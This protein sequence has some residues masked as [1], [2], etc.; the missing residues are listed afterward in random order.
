MITA[1]G[2]GERIEDL[3]QRTESS[4]VY[5]NPDGTWTSESSLSPERV[6]DELG[7]WHPID[8]TLVETPDGNWS[9]RHAASDV[10]VSGGGEKEFVSMSAGKRDIAWKWP[11]TLPAPQVSGSTAT[12]VGV[13]EDG[14]LLVTATAEGFTYNVRLNERPDVVPDIRANVTTDGARLVE[15][16]SG[17]FDLTN[18]DR[19]LL[20]SAPPVM[21]DAS[22]DPDGAGGL[23]APVDSTATQTSKNS[24]LV[25]LNPDPDFLLDPHTQYPVIVDPS[26]SPDIAHDRTVNNRNVAE[27]ATDLRA[28]TT[29][30]GTT[31]YRAFLKFNA[32][33]DWN[34]KNIV[35]ADLKLRNFDSNVCSTKAIRASRVNAE[36]TPSALTW[37]N[38]PVVSG[39]HYDDFGQAYGGPSC[40]ADDAIWN[41]ASTVQSWADGA[42]ENYGFRIAAVD[43]SSNS[44][45]R[46]YRS[47]EATAWVPRLNVTYN[48]YPSAATGT[49]LVSMT[50]NG[51]ALTTT[52][53]L[54]ATVRD[55]DGGSVRA[56]FQVLNTAGGLVWEGY[57]GFVGDGRTA[58]TTVPAGLLADGQTYIV[59]AITNDGSLDA[60]STGPSTTFTV[61]ASKPVATI[62]AS[63]F[64][65]GQWLAEAPAQNVF[66]ITGPSDTQSFLISKDDEWLFPGTIFTGSSVTLPWLPAA[67]GHSLSV[68][69]FDHAGNQGPTVVFKFGVGAATLVSPQKQ[70]RSTK[71]FPMNVQGPP[72][73]ISADLRWRFAGDS[74]WHAASNVS[75]PTGS[76]WSNSVSTSTDGLMSTTGELRWSAGS[77]RYLTA[78]DSDVWATLSAPAQIHV[79]GCFQYGGTRAEVCTKP[80]PVQLVASAFGPNFPTTKVGPAS[81]ALATGEV[82]IAAADAADTSAGLARAFSSFDDATLHAGPFGPG[83]SSSVLS[84]GDTAGRLVDNRVQDRTFVLVSAGNASE[85]F[86]PLDPSVDPSTT[87]GPLTFVSA[88]VDDGSRLVVNGATAVLT[89]PNA[90]SSTSWRLTEA[91]DWTLDS[92]AAASSNASDPEVKAAYSQ[93]RLTWLSQTA[94]G[95]AATCTA[96]VQTNNCRGLRITYQNDRVTKIE[97]VIAGRPAVDVAAYTYDSSGRLATVCDPRA[98]PATCAEY[99]YVVVGGRTLLASYTNVGLEPWRFQYDT[100]GRLTHVRRTLAPSSGTGEAVWT[101]AY[102]LLPTAAGLPPMTASAVAQW[103][104]SRVP[105]RVVAAFGPDRPISGAPSSEDMKRASVWWLDANGSVTNSGVY[106]AGDWLVN[107]A[108]QDSHGNT[109]RT[110]DGRG[111]QRV[112]AADAFDRVRAAVG[113]STFTRWSPDGRRVEDEFS[114]VRP[115]TLRDGTRG[116]YREHTAFVYDD[117]APGLGGGQ[118]PSPPEGQTSLDV[119]V[120]ERTSTAKPDLTGEF[121]L[122][123]LRYEYAP[124]VAGDAN[125]W[126]T[127]SPTKTILAQPDGGF[128]TRVTRRDEDGR[129]IESRQPGGAPTSNGAG[130]DAR[131]TRYTY[132]LPGAADLDCDTEEE[133]YRVSWVG[134]TCKV[135]PAA[136]PTGKQIPTTYVS[137]YNQ[138][139][140]PTTMVERAGADLRMTTIAYDA[141]GREQSMSVTRGNESRSTTFTTDPVTGRVATVTSGS[142]TT[143]T[144]YDSWGRTASYQDGNGFVTTTTYTPDSKTATRTEGSRTYTYTYDSASD[145]RRLPSNVQISGLGSFALRHD[146]VGAVDTVTYPNGLV[147]DYENDDAGLVHDLEYRDGDGSSL[148]SFTK[149][150]TVA[151][152]TLSDVTPLGS[153]SYDYDASG[154]LTEVRSESGGG[155]LT[156]KY[157]YNATSERTG[158]DTFGTTADGACEERFPFASVTHNYDTANR[159]TNAGYVYDNFGRTT[160]VPAVDTAAGGTG[161]LQLTYH[162]NDAVASM[163]QAAGPILK[164]TYYDLDAPGRIASITN[165]A[166]SESNPLLRETSRIRYRFANEGDSPSI[167]QTSTDQGAT[168]TTS[169]YIALDGVGM[170]AVVDAT[171]TTYQLQNIDGDTVATQQAG[172]SSTIQSYSEFDEFGGGTSGSRYGW[173]GGS[174]RSSDTLGGLMLMGERVYNPKTGSFLTMDPVAN[175]GPTRYGYMTDPVNSADPS[176]TCCDI[177]GDIIDG[178]GDIVGSAIEAGKDVGKDVIYNV[179]TVAFGEVLPFAC[180]VT[181]LNPALAVACGGLVGALGGLLDYALGDVWRDGETWNGGDAKSAAWDGFLQGMAGALLGKLTLKMFKGAVESILDSISSALHKVKVTVLDKYFA[182]I[183]Y[184]VNWAF[185][186]FKRRFG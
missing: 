55:P 38:Q 158:L 122:T 133:L 162:L 31:K 22:G 151:G 111:R 165:T 96:T 159:I 125:G 17:G 25:D 144:T 28:G 69:A 78:P 84:V 2:L 101:M 49:S 154:R 72:G 56:R 184:F 19:V 47:S 36:W 107:T 39:S 61:D 75:T 183:K 9:P 6:M 137:A 91:G 146:A 134:L 23:V 104:Q 98:T 142:S 16:E 131:A 172:S 124:I 24:G 186:K 123:R 27:V 163:S 52:P 126:T 46:R 153:R 92:A 119:V 164:T 114:S 97:R 167:V 157:S 63:S 103:G 88:G 37:A 108:W 99:T 14:D 147:A 53:Q 83:W 106:G 115:A 68:T 185:K 32:Q 43:D 20:A 178:A 170:I 77:Q 76:A 138:D 93:G 89:R 149:T 35:S 8:T 34:G 166:T 141:L 13:V 113:A 80:T 181:K 168:W 127:A 66:T 135:G 100:D 118:K 171:G 60:K 87:P 140:R 42:I 5:A 160:S 11:Q 148:L 1:R 117:E 62:A 73:A 173:Q 74:V 59:R 82:A 177:I 71:V 150:A 65:N 132:Y 51:Y 67:G 156:R 155:C 86:E 4:K 180:G 112:L 54:Q 152:K 169:E 121:D 116:E 48:S 85:T 21:W 179:A 70:L 50:A 58:K 15:H 176:G 110:L 161:S 136:Q 57:S 79:A 109:V 95:V 10:V 130:G 129:V 33:G 3:S 26:I 128:R 40:V 30:G 174:Q 45:W 102:D 145:F 143:T 18:G 81:V 41:V 105:T 120:E 29:D 139:L 44:S 12:Y 175:G 7:A 90:A 182:K 94:P 64:V